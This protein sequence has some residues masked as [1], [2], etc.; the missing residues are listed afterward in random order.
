M[1][2]YALV[3]EYNGAGTVGFQRQTKREAPPPS[4]R[5]R[6]V[7]HSVQEEL[8]NKLS[9]IFNESIS[10]D[11]AGR[12]DAGVHA[13]GQIVAFYASKER[14]AAEIMRSANAVLAP[15]IRVLR[16]SEVHADFRPRYHARRRIYHYYILPEQGRGED[17]FWEDKA[18]I[19]PGG[20]D[21]EAMQAAAD[22]LLGDHDFRAYS[23]GEPS[24]KYTRRTLI[25]LDISR[26]Q[27]VGAGGG[28]F[29]RLAPLLCL[30][31]EA[32]AFLKRMVRQIAG[33]L[34]KVGR[35]EW[36][37]ERPLRVLKSKDPGQ[38]AP[39]APS[40]GVFLVG[41]H[42]PDYPDLDWNYPSPP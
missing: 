18:W 25:R 23:R 26:F 30:K 13:T 32:N 40:Q 2:R 41:M 38:G 14:A 6:I 22:L 17:P 19:V 37:I 7:T 35:G 28:P 5:R 1:K 8:E 20:L 34:V 15:F 3:L 33:N 42:F 9:Q 24:D 29:A 12:T 4:A 10:I 27:A 21:V 36:D 16:C 39:P 11:A 31:V